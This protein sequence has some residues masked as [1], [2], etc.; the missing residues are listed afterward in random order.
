[1]MRSQKP[2]E[3]TIMK[4]LSLLKNKVKKK[5]ETK[6]SIEFFCMRIVCDLCKSSVSETEDRRQVLVSLAV[7]WKG[8][9][10]NC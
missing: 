10:R 1:M 5:G 3:N 4:R 6:V 9:G 2:A 8:E 7:S